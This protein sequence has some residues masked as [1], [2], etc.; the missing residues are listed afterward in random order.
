MG[1]TETWPAIFSYYW[2]PF[3]QQTTVSGQLT[4]EKSNGQESKEDREEKDHKEED[5]QEGKE[6]DRE[7]E[8]IVQGPHQMPAETMCRPAKAFD[9][10]NR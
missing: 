10:T 7:E 3:I 1:M 5:R 9:A 4:K 2:I 8:E 6:E